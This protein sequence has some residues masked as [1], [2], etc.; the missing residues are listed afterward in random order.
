MTASPRCLVAGAGAIGSIIAGYLRRSGA[1]VTV[2]DGWFQNVL[3]IRRL[4]LRVQSPEETFRVEVPAL[5]LDELEG[6]APFDIVFLAV[7]S[8]DTEPMARLVSPYLAPGG[9]IVSTQN[10]INETRIAAIVGAD[11][12]VGCVVHM[13]GGLFEPGVVTRYSSPGWG[14][15]H[16]GE[17]DG[18]LTP[19]L[20][21]LAALLAAIGRT[22][23]TT[24][25]HGEL[26]GK[27]ALNCMTNGLAG[28]SGLTS[29]KLWMEPETAALVVRLAAETAAVAS[30][31][32][33]DMAPVHPTGAPRGLDPDLLARVGAGDPVAMTD[34][35]GLLHAAG[36]A[37]AGGRENKASML[38]DVL[39]HRRTEIDYLNGHVVAQGRRGE[40]KT[41]ANAAVVT[42]VKEIE[43][44]AREPGDD[45][46]RAILGS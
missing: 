30:A 4:G 28:I 26:W 3:A 1:S 27:L 7:K 10:G 9:F 16:V 8:Y 46:W 15:F 25:I 13:N 19:R 32:G 45:G 11:R 22:E 35:A 14:T 34:A 36:A 12:T 6:A 31:V 39:K 23:V 40:I 44:G 20:T 5:N 2:A 33:V 43:A 18:R 38:Q 29:P 17:L 42:M 21:A 37:R 24:N 41:P